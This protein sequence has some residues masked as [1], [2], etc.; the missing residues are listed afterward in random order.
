MAKTAFPSPI[1]SEPLRQLAL[2]PSYENQHLVQT[3]MPRTNGRAVPWAVRRDRHHQPHLCIRRRLEER[4]RP[5]YID[6]NNLTTLIQPTAPELSSSPFATN[7]APDDP[8]TVSVSPPPSTPPQASSFPLASLPLEILHSVCSYLHPTDISVLESL[9]SALANNIAGLKIHCNA[10]ITARFSYEAALFAPRL[11]NGWLVPSYEAVKG[12]RNDAP[13]FRGMLL[14]SI[15][16]TDPINSAKNTQQATLTIQQNALITASSN[17]SASNDCLYYASG[18]HFARFLRL[19]T[20]KYIYLA[21][22]ILRMSRYRSP[23]IR[24][25][26]RAF[27]K[28]VLA[29]AVGKWRW[30][31]NVW[32]RILDGREGYGGSEGVE[33]HGRKRG[34]DLWWVKHE[35]MGLECLDGLPRSAKWLLDNASYL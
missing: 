6:N 5:I 29:W 4:S 21:Q 18:P 28:A 13:F 27:H 17:S 34:K 10:T 11:H 35:E 20:K 26:E 31:T 32:V 19:F 24:W 15:T 30:T 23:G 22:F 33:V 16:S 2:S 9:S 1:S 25:D 12:M 3:N 14:T 8:I 7:R